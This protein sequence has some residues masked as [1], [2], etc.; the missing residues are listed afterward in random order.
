MLEPNPYN[1]KIASGVEQPLLSNEEVIV[2]APEF[3]T[4]GKRDATGAFH[5]GA[6]MFCDYYGLDREKVVHYIDNEN[7]KH[8][9]ARQLLSKMEAARTVWPET[10]DYLYPQVYVFFCHGYIS[11]IQFGIRSPTPG[12]RFTS[13]DRGHWE[14]FVAAIGRHPAPVVILYACS[15]GDDPDDDPNS[16]PGSGDDSFGDLL[17][18]ALCARQCTF[19]RVVTHYSPGHTFYNRDIKIMDGMGSPIGGHG[20]LPLAKNGSKT[21]KALGQLLKVKPGKE[22]YGFAWRF[23]FMTVADIH[24]ELARKAGLI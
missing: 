14:R 18:D 12:R 2:F 5:P 11:G 10:G 17:R 20:G 8:I 19:N 3:N 15:T 1:D 23:P 7:S 9:Q 4:Q 6:K 22:G 21:Y 24:S 13:T 16:A